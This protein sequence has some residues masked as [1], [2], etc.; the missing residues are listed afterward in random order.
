MALNDDVHEL[1][2]R[3]LDSHAG[4]GGDPASLLRQLRQSRDSLLDLLR[5]MIES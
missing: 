4:Q 2:T 5:E 3:L 1:A